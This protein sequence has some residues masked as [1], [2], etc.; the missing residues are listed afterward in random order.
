MLPSSGATLKTS[1]WTIA[2]GVTTTAPD[3]MTTFRATGHSGISIIEGS[4]AYVELLLIGFWWCEL[5]KPATLD[6]R[7]RR[8]Q[9]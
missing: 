7:P 8:R 3:A 5:A 1:S 2:G 9:P 4:D 6:L